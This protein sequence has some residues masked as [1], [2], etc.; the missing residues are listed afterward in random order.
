MKYRAIIREAWT[1]TQGNKKLIWWFAFV[2][3]LLELLVGMVYLS[4]Q[5]ASFWNNPYFREGAE[6]SHIISE[7]FKGLVDLFHVQPGLVVFGLVVVAIILLAYLFLPVFTQGSLIQLVAYIRAGQPVSIAKGISF[8]FSRFLQLFE[9][10][11]FVKTFSM[12][13]IITEAS[14]ALRI[15]GPKPFEVL[16]WIFLLFIVVGLLLTLLMTY[17]EYY[18]VIDKE[19]VFNSVIKS[20][21]LVIRQWHH[22]L[23]MLFLMAIIVLRIALNLLVALLIP[24]LVLGPIYFFTSI[25]VAKIGAVVGGVI[26]LVVL[27]FSSYFLGVFHVFATTVWTFTFLELTKEEENAVNLHHAPAHHNQEAIGNAED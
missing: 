10:G 19:G 24:A 25:T 27:Y 6:G 8:G 16:G 12:V 23:F 15:L 17:S 14:F 1:L 18:I 5:A 13:G 11:L 3:A 22:T 4:Y 7:V 21:G 20:G 2:P 26:G 9:Y